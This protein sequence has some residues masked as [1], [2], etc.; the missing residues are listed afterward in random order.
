MQMMTPA[1]SCGRLSVNA[2]FQRARSSTPGRGLLVCSAFELQ[3]CPPYWGS[4]FLGGGVAWVTSGHQRALAPRREPG[5]GGL[6]ADRGSWGGP[7]AGGCL[8]WG[9]S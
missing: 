9:P 5:V 2:H 7:G 8:R 3:G 6:Q 1:S 4:R